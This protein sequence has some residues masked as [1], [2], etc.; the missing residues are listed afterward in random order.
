MTISIVK[1]QK[2]KSYNPHDQAEAN[3]PTR[4]NPLNHNE[5]TLTKFNKRTPPHRT[6]HR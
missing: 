5:L 1:L 4:E 3:I 2:I 6:P